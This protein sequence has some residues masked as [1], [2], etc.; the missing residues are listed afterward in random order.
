MS[1]AFASTPSGEIPS[2]I[3]TSA[4][5]SSR[6]YL[7]TWQ[8]RPR[9][10]EVLMLLKFS[11]LNLKAVRRSLLAYLREVCNGLDVVHISWLL[12]NGRCWIRP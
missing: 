10:Q 11:V 5:E 3:C 8:E 9:T 1:R 2:E 6:S 12:G 7:E 4:L